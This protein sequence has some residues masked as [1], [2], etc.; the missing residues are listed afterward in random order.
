[1]PRS[2]KTR[3]AYKMEAYLK[4][5]LKISIET[6]ASALPKLDEDSITVELFLQLNEEELKTDYYFPKAD[7][8]RIRMYK[9]SL[10]GI[11]NYIVSTLQ[12][13]SLA[14]T[15]TTTTVAATE[16]TTY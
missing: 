2:F 9:D 12:L 7:V 4:N 5:V 8:L 13:I 10:K 15:T 16:T 1:M 6:V 3:G 14:T 11:L